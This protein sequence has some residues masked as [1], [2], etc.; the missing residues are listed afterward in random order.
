MKELFLQYLNMLYPLFQYDISILSQKW[1]IFTIIPA[2]LYLIFFFIKWAV[3][4]TP[5]WL[6]ISLALS[7]L[8]IF[9]NRR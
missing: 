3:L 9:K 2:A 1:M 8:S 5:L 7:G 6:P 4:T